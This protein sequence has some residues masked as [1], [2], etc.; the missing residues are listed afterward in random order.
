MS[1]NKFETWFNKNREKMY[2]PSNLPTVIDVDISDDIVQKEGQKL[3]I[4]HYQGGKW[5]DLG[6]S[7]DSKIMSLKGISKFVLAL[8][9]LT[10]FIQDELEKFQVS[11][12][13]TDPLVYKN[14]LNTLLVHTKKSMTEFGIASTP[15][16]FDS[17]FL[18]VSENKFARRHLMQSEPKVITAALIFSIIQGDPH[19][20]ES[21]DLVL[22]K[23]LHINKSILISITYLYS[24]GLMSINFLNLVNKYH[25][26]LNNDVFKLI[27]D[28]NDDIKRIFPDPEELEKGSEDDEKVKNKIEPI[29]VQPTLSKESINILQ[30]A[31]VDITDLNSLDA[32][33]LEEI[34]SR[35]KE[36]YTIKGKPKQTD[37]ASA[38]TEPNS[39]EKVKIIDERM[40]T[41]K[42]ISPEKKGDQN[43]SGLSGGNKPAPV[44]DA[45]ETGYAVS[46]RPPPKIEEVVEKLDKISDN[47][48][49]S[50]LKTIITELV[51]K[52]MPLPGAPPLKIYKESELPSNYD[53]NS[54]EYF[55]LTYHFPDDSVLK[56]ASY[57]S[58]SRLSRQVVPGTFS[59]KKYLNLLEK[60]PSEA[61]QMLKSLESIW[62]HMISESCTMRGLDVTNQYLGQTELKAYEKA[63][64]KNYSQVFETLNATLLD[65][66][67]Y[68]IKRTIS[69]TMSTSISQGHEKPY[70]YKIDRPIDLIQHASSQLKST[71]ST[72]KDKDDNTEKVT[73]IETT[74]VDKSESKGGL[75]DDWD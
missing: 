49:H 4:K 45:E 73:V 8:D 26:G 47:L 11:V 44:K 75:F 41:L 43:K 18:E 12:M 31:G 9:Q 39:P 37:E 33:K 30:K 16:K 67:K 42:E 3:G 1:Y 6:K 46:D 23:K 56:H 57:S 62:S 22:S 25:Y 24:N 15:D 51:G 71:S 69:D 2:L 7:T 35:F 74:K 32:D 27:Y 40:K 70:E 14:Y 50:D 61:T 68:L 58:L 28:K 72:Q 52:T 48:K 21:K 13:V 60:E 65:D 54:L 34:M 66:I 53:T 59:P 10:S 63:I 55:L 38:N 17:D 20:L 29:G 64:S 19:I 36:G 5:V